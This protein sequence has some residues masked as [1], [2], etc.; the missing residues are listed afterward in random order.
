MSGPRH[1]LVLAY[2]FPP[3][4]GAGVQRTLKALKYLPEHGWRATV[5]TTSSSAYPLSDASLDAEIPAGTRVVRAFEPRGLARLQQLAVMALNR[6][7]LRGLRDLA[8][9]PDLMAGWGVFALL[10]ALRMAR[11][12]RPDVIYSSGP[13]FTGQIVAAILHRLTGIP[14][15][16]DF[17]DEWSENPHGDQ[18]RFV[19]AISR[20]TERWIAAQAHAV[21]GV[22]DYFRIA[23]VA[24]DDLVVIP[25]GVD[26]Q[27]LAAEPAGER[28][29]DGP[30]RLSHVGTLYGDR[31][32]DP[33]FAAMRRLIE[34]GR[35]DAGA[36]ELRVVG[37][38]W[39][40]DLDAR[41]PVPLSRTGY[42]SHREAV[43]EMFSADALLLYVAPTSLAPSG[44]L[45]E[46]LA[47][48]RPI[49]CVA[50]PDNLASRLVR[51][52]D[53]G[54]WAAPDDGAAIEAAILELL[55]RR[56]RGALTVDPGV[57]RRVLERYSRRALAG[58]LAE[59]LAAAAG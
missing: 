7:R 18:A 15:V 1:V 24:P 27:D 8:G 52:W 43:G 17:R 6:L 20:R 56:D 33:V 40:P 31:D 54:V 9:W 35:L 5:V 53:A 3:I 48:G 16:T 14:C 36:I 34:A 57:R 49:L 50:H 46:Y 59:V 37:S 41:V 10:A 55:A 42:V 26:E 25:N 51:E 23:G 2:F 4:G 12:D 13:P 11:R 44:K 32:A 22:A 30:L 47:S 45:F 29:S 28:A 19:R 39:L 58:R 38:D 21:I